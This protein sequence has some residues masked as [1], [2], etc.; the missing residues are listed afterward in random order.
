MLRN[1]IKIL[2]CSMVS[3][4]DIPLK[5]SITMSKTKYLHSVLEVCFGRYDKI[6]EFYLNI[7][8]LKLCKFCSTFSLCQVTFNGT[9]KYLQ[10]ALHKISFISINA[11]YNLQLYNVKYEK[12]KLL[13][14]SK[15][16]I[17]YHSEQHDEDDQNDR[18]Y[19]L[20]LNSRCPHRL[21]RKPCSQCH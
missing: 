8:I 14:T 19:H 21:R 9:L 17:L 18:H 16:S 7:F 3:W 4:N 5:K 13:L 12:K 6:H 1:S 2:T 10:Y 20:R 11:Q 15:G